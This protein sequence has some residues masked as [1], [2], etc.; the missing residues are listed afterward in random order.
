MGREVQAFYTQATSDEKKDRD[1]CMDDLRY[2][3]GTLWMFL[4]IG[5]AALLGTDFILNEI[6]MILKERRQPKAD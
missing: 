1:C 4:T 6:R 5:A 3:V 2:A